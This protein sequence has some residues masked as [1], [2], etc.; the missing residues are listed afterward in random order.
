MIK[1]GK[2]G[3]LTKSGLTFESRIDLKTLFSGIKG[4]TIAAMICILMVN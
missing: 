3:S 2:G 4:Y 1:G